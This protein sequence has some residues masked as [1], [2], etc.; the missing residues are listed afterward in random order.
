MFEPSNLKILELLNIDPTRVKLGILNMSTRN[1]SKSIN[2]GR[3]MLLISALTSNSEKNDF[4]NL[5]VFNLM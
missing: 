5:R 2:R 3:L 4:F 1:A